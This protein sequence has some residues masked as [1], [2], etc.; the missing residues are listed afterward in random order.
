MYLFA[1]SLIIKKSPGSRVSALVTGTSCWVTAPRSPLMW[2]IWLCFL[3]WAQR[4]L[5][6]TPS[7]S[8]SLHFLSSGMQKIFHCLV[9]WTWA[10]SEECGWISALGRFLPVCSAPRWAVGCSLALV[11]VLS[12]APLCCARVPKLCVYRAWGLY[13]AW[14]IPKIVELVKTC[15]YEN[16]HSFRRTR[17]AILV[18]LQA[19]EWKVSWFY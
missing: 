12:S 1:E 18:Y 3:S 14:Q 15:R 4:F 5:S 13:V 6:R 16:G 19:W 9:F 10:M 8:L 2:C 7:L 17:P 11:V